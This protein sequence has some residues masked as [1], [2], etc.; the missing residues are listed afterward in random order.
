MNRQSQWLFEA[1]ASPEAA[2]YAHLEYY[3]LP[4]EEAEWEQSPSSSS[5]G[6]TIRETIWGFSQYSHAIPPQEKAKILKLAQLIVQSYRSESPIRTVRLVGHADRDVQRGANFEKKI[7]G[8]RA[9]TVQQ[10]LMYAINN[11]AI[12]S[13]ISWQRVSR[14]VSQLIVKNPNTEKARSRNRRVG[15]L[16]TTAQSNNQPNKVKWTTGALA[17]TIRKAS[18]SSCF[19]TA[20]PGFISL[21]SKIPDCIGTCGGPIMERFKIFFHVD[22][23]IQPRPQPFKLPKVSVVLEVI[24]AQGRSKFSKQESDPTPSYQGPGKPLKTSFGEDFII[25]LAPGDTLRVNLQMNDSSSGITV[26]YADSISV[27]KLP[28]I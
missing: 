10:A 28:C 17:V 11:R 9:L 25:P 18:N 13:R 7:S 5:R 2:L 26:N 16:L 4:E 24:T 8:D 20:S 1:P 23:D 3:S 6:Q 22:A 12:S 27:V 15:L 21:L 14:G 19:G